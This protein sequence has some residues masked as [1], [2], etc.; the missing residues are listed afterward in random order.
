MTAASNHGS[1]AI[2]D[3]N[4]LQAGIAL[5]QGHTY[6]V[7]FW[8][9]ADT[10]RILR[11]NIV[12]SGGSYQGE[13]FAADRAL[14]STWQQY[15]FTFQAIA[16]DQNTQLGFYFGAETGNTWLDGVVVQDTAP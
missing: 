11:S 5:Q 13:G 15:F 3:V 2:S 4:L 8:A 9:K 7:Q 12:H 6:R 1:N 10:A 14:S 16:T